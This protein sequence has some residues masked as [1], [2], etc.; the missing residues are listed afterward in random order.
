M[1]RILVADDEQPLRELFQDILENEG[2][3]VETAADGQSALQKILDGGYDLILLDVIMPNMDGITVL[4]KLQKQKLKVPNGPIVVLSV[5]EEVDF[6]KT[7]LTLGAEGYIQKSMGTPED[8]INQVKKMMDGG[9]T[10]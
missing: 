6:M 3:V 2:Y 5:L 1:P 4:R 8:I 10:I 7:C 9:S